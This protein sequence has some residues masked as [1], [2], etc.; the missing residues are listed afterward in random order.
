MRATHASKAWTKKWAKN[1]FPRNSVSEKL[2]NY[3]KSILITE[4][5][6]ILF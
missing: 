6:Y 1:A 2:I 3:H 4:T 5:N